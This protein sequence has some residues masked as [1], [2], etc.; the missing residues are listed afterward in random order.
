M[1]A[2]QINGTFRTLV[3]K[4]QEKSGHVLGNKRQVLR[5]LQRQVLG[6]AEKRLGDLQESAHRV[7][8]HVRNLNL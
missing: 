6:L 4:V 5:G 1:N 7:V 2:N 8:G 3:G